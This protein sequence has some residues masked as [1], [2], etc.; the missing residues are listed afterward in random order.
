[1]AKYTHTVVG[2]LNKIA[3]NIR[4]LTGRPV[5]GH[6]DERRW[7]VVGA[8]EKIAASI[9]GIPTCDI[10]GNAAGPYEEAFVTYSVGTGTVR[11]VKQGTLKGLYIIVTGEM[12]TLDGQRHGQ[13]EAVFKAGFS[14]P[15]QV[16]KYPPP[17][18]P[19]YDRPSKVDPYTDF[20]IDD[21]KARW[22]FADGSSLSAPGP[23]ISYIAPLKDGGVQFWVSAAAFI[24]GGT[25][26]YA[27]A[28]GQET[29]LG[30]TYFP[31]PPQLVDG[32]TFP[33]HVI[34]CFRVVKA[35]DRAPIPPPPP[36]KKSPPA[37]KPGPKRKRK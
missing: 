9:Q 5:N 28:V 36:P 27:G 1:M 20:I 37:P 33:A 29:S 19:P 16:L 11:E 12:Y 25:G 31:T 2:A 35:S 6:V 34:H 8:L 26:R 15:L 13:Y 17:A 21:T 7:T 4:T 22:T 23:A 24:T 18:E 32:T 3:D 14:N 10:Q 30:S